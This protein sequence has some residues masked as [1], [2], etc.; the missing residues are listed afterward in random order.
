M[1]AV[2]ELKAV[3]RDRV[4]KGAARA[5][6]LTGQ[7]PAVIYGGGEPP[8]TIA[9]NANDTQ[10]LVY[11]GHFLTTV[12]E[13]DLDGAKT[14]VIPRD[15][16]LDPV[17]DT[18][19]HVDFLRLAAGQT[20][21]IEI[22]VHFV[23]HETSPGLKRGGTLNVVRHTVELVVPS[24]AIPES[25]EADLSALDMGASLHISAMKLPD[26]VRSVI[27]RDF[28]VATIAAP[29]ELGQEAEAEAAAITEAAKAE[30][31][32]P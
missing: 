18:L 14:R 8:R 26:G 32:K 30:S 4:G 21:T 24:D 15:Y 23:G 25:I 31:A 27:D 16:Q 20:L 10:R 19:V 13:V 1:S 29:A 7:V 17:K 22:P 3:A 6:R 9:L 5:V 2:K 11:A 28:T 12:F